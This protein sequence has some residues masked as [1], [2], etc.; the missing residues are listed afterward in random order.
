MHG[1][2]TALHVRWRRANKTD[3]GWWES[4]F[5]LLGEGVKDTKGEAAG[6]ESEISMWTHVQFSTDADRQTQK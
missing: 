3:G 5:S 2:E 6:L 4:A 1:F